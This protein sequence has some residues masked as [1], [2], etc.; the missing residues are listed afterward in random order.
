M[1]CRSF[2]VQK[3]NNAQDGVDMFLSLLHFPVHVCHLRL[4]IVI[5]RASWLHI[6][7]GNIHDINVTGNFADTN[8]AR[9]RGRN[10][11]VMNTTVYPPGERPAAAQAI[12]TAAGALASKSNLWH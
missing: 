10:C 2:S 1:S 4:S 12:I 11:P 6:W 9:N 8:R 7:T 5:P 3:D